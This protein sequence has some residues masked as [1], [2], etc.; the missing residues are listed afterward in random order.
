MTIF[1]MERLSW[2]ISVGLKCHCNI[3]VRDNVVRF[4]TQKRRGGYVT[5]NAENRMMQHKESQ[6]LPEVGRD[7]E[8]VHF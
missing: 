2:I 1:E 7:M 4:E 3:F 5:T 6:Q 8:R